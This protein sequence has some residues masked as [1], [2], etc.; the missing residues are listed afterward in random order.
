MGQK[1]WTISLSSTSSHMPCL[2]FIRFK[3]I[4]GYDRGAPAAL[5]LAFAAAVYSSNA[6][7]SF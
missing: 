6:L 4:N 5:I 1:G 3:Y 7:S 2:Y